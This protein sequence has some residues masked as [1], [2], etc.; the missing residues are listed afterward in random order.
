MKT[1]TQNPYA[2]YTCS[3][4]HHSFYFFIFVDLWKEKRREQRQEQE[5]LNKKKA[6]RQNGTKNHLFNLTFWDGAFALKYGR[7]NDLGSITKRTVLKILQLHF[8]KY[9]LDPTR[10]QTR[11]SRVVHCILIILLKFRIYQLISTVRVV[12]CY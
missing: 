12:S 7:K 10:D 3:W 4:H 6:R 8:N 9:I 11:D 2:A 1:A 5:I